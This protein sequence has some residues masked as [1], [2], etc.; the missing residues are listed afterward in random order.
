MSSSFPWDHPLIAHVLSETCTDPDCEVHNVDVGLEEDVLTAANVA[1]FCAGFMK[2]AEGC[3]PEALLEML[4]P[5][6][7]E[8][9]G[10]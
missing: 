4:G 2:A 7:R 1:F 9:Y 5:K 10:T 8:M 6:A 3:S